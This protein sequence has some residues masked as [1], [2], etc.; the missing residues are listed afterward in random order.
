MRNN[1]VVIIA[2]LLSVS[3]FSQNSQH[4]IPKKYVSVEGGLGVD[5]G[6]VANTILN[7]DASRDIGVFTYSLSAQAG[8]RFTNRLALSTGVQYAYLTPDFH[9]IYWRTHGF[10]YLGDTSDESF[11]YLSLSYG[12]QL[13]FSSG[14]D[15]SVLGFSFGTGE[16]IH[17]KTGHNMSLFLDLYTSENPVLMVGVSYR[18]ML[19]SKRK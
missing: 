10:I 11:N 19:F 8:Y 1:I 17:G 2:L 7:N 16:I 4:A 5:A 13:N 9:P 18:I 3:I 14:R 12:K 6:W 15:I